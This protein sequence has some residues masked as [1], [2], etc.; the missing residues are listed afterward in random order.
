LLLALALAASPA[1]RRL[2]MTVWGGI[3]LCSALAFLEVH[4]L[5]AR[6]KPGEPQELVACE[7]DGEM[8]RLPVSK[9]RQL[10]NLK[11][12][13][14]ARVRP[15]EKV[16]IAPGR[17]ALYSVLGKVAPTWWIY[18]FWTATDAE[19]RALIDE[20]ATKGVNWVLVVDR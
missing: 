12:F 18:F 14:R 8:L 10:E 4:S 9:A 17:P 6:F 3:A 5:I 20:L 15:E 16:F 2:R 11:A 7:V 13:F 19:Q 1:R